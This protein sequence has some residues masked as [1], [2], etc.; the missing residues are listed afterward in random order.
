[1]DRSRRPAFGYCANPTRLDALGLTQGV[2]HPVCDLGIHP[3]DR[4][5]CAFVQE[6][7]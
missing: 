6:P 3:L 1:M 7:A 5:L 2:V 4:I